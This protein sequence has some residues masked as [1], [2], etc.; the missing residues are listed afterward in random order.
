LETLA[1]QISESTLSTGLFAWT[2]MFDLRITQMP[3][4]VP[5]LGPLLQVSPFDEHHLE[6]RYLDTFNKDDQWYRI[7]DAD[8]ALPRLISFLDQLRWFPSDV[9]QSVSDSYAEARS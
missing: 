6:F 1:R 3:V 8:Q 2:S 7:V 5:Y 4:S 9:L